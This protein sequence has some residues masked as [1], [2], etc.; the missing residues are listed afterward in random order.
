MVTKQPSRTDLPHSLIDGM[1]TSGTTLRRSLVTMRPARKRSSGDVF[2]FRQ[3]PPD[4]PGH[5][6]AAGVGGHAPVPPSTC[7]VGR[8]T[9]TAR[10]L[11]ESPLHVGHE[12]HPGRQR[13]P[14]A[15]DAAR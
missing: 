7:P 12:H 2:P 1:V 11:L 8:A 4:A 10:L 6:P 15:R 14:Q 3:R 5:P 13:L 9:V